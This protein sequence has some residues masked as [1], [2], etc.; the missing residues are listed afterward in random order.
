MQVP[1]SAIVTT[2]RSS[3]IFLSYS[4]LLSKIEIFIPHLY[5]APRKGVTPSEFRDD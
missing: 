2:E 5:L 1:I 3:I 4:E